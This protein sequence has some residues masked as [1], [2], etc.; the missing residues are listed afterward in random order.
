MKK[1]IPYFTIGTFGIIVTALLQ[2]SITLFIPAIAVQIIFL[3]LYPVFI[4]C[5]T[6]GFFKLLKDQ[7]KELT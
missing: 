4:A 5:L 3:V 2:I 1:K 7:K 6:T